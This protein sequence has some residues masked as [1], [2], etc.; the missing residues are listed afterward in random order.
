MKKKNEDDFLPNAYKHKSSWENNF[1]KWGIFFCVTRNGTRGLAYA[2]H[3]LYLW[4]TFLGPQRTFFSLRITSIVQI[5]WVTSLFPILNFRES[6]TK[7]TLKTP[8]KNGYS[9]IPVTSLP[10]ETTLLLCLYVQTFPLHALNYSKWPKKVQ[11]SKV[12]LIVTVHL[13]CSWWE[14]RRTV[15]S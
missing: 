15:V 9:F 2:E 6:M 11:F 5:F 8:M 13:F 10:T 4:A 1:R 14:P 3:G 12:L 7:V